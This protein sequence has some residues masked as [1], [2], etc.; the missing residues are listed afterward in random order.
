MWLNIILK[1][2]TNRRIKNFRTLTMTFHFQINVANTSIELSKHNIYRMLR[3]LFPPKPEILSNMCKQG[4]D[5]AL[6]FLNRNNLIS[7]ARCLAIQSTFV[8][9][10]TMDECLEYDPECKEC[11]MQRQVSRAIWL[12]RQFVKHLL[13]RQW[14]C[15][16]PGTSTWNV[17]KSKLFVQLIT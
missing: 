3:I 16:V 11:T 1:Y 7:C 9:Q 14:F 6:R 17:T 4:F 5:D 12:R 10:N 8:V 2:R 13:W 15:I